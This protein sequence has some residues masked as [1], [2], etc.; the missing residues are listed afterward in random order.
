MNSRGNHDQISL[1]QRYIFSV[2]NDHILNAV[3][4]AQLRRRLPLWNGE[5]GAD[6]IGALRFDAAS[7]TMDPLVYVPSAGT[8]VREHGC[9]SGT[10]AVGCHLAVEAGRDVEAPVRQPG[11]TITVCAALSG[12]AVTRLVITGRVTL[13]EE[14]DW[15]D[16][17]AADKF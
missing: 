10:A 12:K 8:L 15:D 17:S 1:R 7:M 2:I 5:I 4:F 6:A 16:G 14:G 3:N 9:G 11:G 13:M